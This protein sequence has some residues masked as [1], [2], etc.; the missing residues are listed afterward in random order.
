MKIN[1]RKL[2]LLLCITLAAAIAVLFLRGVLKAEGPKDILRCASDACFVSGVV[3][4]VVGGLIWTA[5]QG[6]ADGLTYGFSR[7][8]TR[9][10]PG[11]EDRRE[12]FSEY[13]ERKHSKKIRVAEFLIS[14]G[15]F[16]ALALLLLIP[17]E[18]LK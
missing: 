10:G 7:F 14:G 5:D 6:V 18:M 4:G 13:K 11:Y 12:S 16:I 8:F 2:I 9:R 17:Y 3:M 15:V 1:G